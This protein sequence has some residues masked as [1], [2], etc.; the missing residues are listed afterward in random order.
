MADPDS[1]PPPSD[2]ELH[3]A[4]QGVQSALEQTLEPGL[5]TG[6]AAAETEEEEGGANTA[7]AKP[8]P[9]QLHPHKGNRAPHTHTH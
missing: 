2:T 1:E 9:P 6:A 3:A 5:E 7:L 4:G 8:R